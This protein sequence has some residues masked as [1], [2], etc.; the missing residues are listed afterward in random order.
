MRRGHAATRP[1][2]HLSDIV[3]VARR[4][5]VRD[6]LT[7]PHSGLH[8]F[9]AIIG[10]LPPADF[11]RVRLIDLLS[12]NIQVFSLQVSRPSFTEMRGEQIQ[13]QTKTVSSGAQILFFLFLIQKEPKK[14]LIISNS[15][16]FVIYFACFCFC[17]DRK[18]VV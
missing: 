4:C 7:L 17:T 8:C 12:P 3:A 2:K 18:S 6:M 15:F 13:Q 14:F 10:P 16:I 9:C 11:V 5:L 1:G